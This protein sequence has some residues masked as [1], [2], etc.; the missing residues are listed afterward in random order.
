MTVHLKHH[1]SDTEEVLV[2][3]KRWCRYSQS[4]TNFHSRNVESNNYR[5]NE[6]KP[7]PRKPVSCTRNL[8]AISRILVALN[9]TNLLESVFIT[10]V[11]TKKKRYEYA[12]A[13]FD[14]LFRRPLCFMNLEGLKIYAHGYIAAEPVSDLDTSALIQLQKDSLFS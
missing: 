10:N 11:I 8:V 12:S 1:I 14:V 5:M 7:F 4:C 9:K 6:T 2:P 13:I 3:H